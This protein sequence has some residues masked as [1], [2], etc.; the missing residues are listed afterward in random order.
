MET[1]FEV[2]NLQASPLLKWAGRKTQLLTV[3]DRC[4][5]STKQS[6]NNYHEPFFGSGALYFHLFSMGKIKQSAYL[7]DILPELSIF[8]NVIKEPRHK[9]VFIEKI[10]SYCGTYNNEGN[11]K[12]KDSIFYSWRENYNLLLRKNPNSLLVK[13]KIELASLLLMLNRTCFNGL[14]RKTKQTGEFNVPHGRTA[15]KT[16]GQGKVS[17]PS[18]NKIDNVAKALEKAT[19]ISGSYEGSLKR[20]RTNDFVYLDPP[21]VE[22]FTGY[23]GEG[24]D[25]EHENLA[26]NFHS[27][28]NS[29]ISVIMSNSDTGRTKEIFN[30]KG[31]YAYRVPVKRTIRRVKRVHQKEDGSFFVLSKDGSEVLKEYENEID[32]K[33]FL[34]EIKRTETKEKNYE[35]ILSSYKISILGESIW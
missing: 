4:F 18:D 1:L 9:K 23:S 35:L 30:N 10:N 31:V 33:L 34:E 19:V 27:L 13:E 6:V 16:K 26:E 24:F 22:N 17:L 14:Y 12:K 7:N 2:S 25:K 29:K 32:A 11:S 28:V 8:Y 5:D 20:V 3:L 21:Y 15:N